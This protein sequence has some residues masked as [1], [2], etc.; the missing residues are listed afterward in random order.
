MRRRRRRAAGAG[1]DDQPAAGH[2]PMSGPSAGGPEPHAAEDRAVAP[3]GD[4]HDGARVVVPVVEVVPGE[5]ALLVD[6][7]LA[8]QRAVRA[9]GGR[10]VGLLDQERAAAGPACCGRRAARRMSSRPVACAGA[11]WCT[12]V[13]VH[14]SPARRRSTLHAPQAAQP[15]LWSAPRHPGRPQLRGDAAR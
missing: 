11:G 12:A 7:H 13:E 4:Q 8:P 10:V 1:R 6:E 9:E 2:Q 15:A 3:A 14:A 5:Q